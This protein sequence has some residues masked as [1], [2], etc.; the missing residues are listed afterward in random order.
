MS[1]ENDY[2]TFELDYFNC[3]P[4]DTMFLLGSYGLC[5]EPFGSFGFSICREVY[6]PKNCYT[7]YDKAI[8]TYS[9]AN[10]I[11]GTNLMLALLKKD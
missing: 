5:V 9:L 2:Y 6:R 11:A 1:K 8:A 4:Y 7:Q 3:A 10:V